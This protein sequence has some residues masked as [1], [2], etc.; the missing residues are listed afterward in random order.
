MKR[1]YNME[2]D[3]KEQIKIAKMVLKAYTTGNFE[4]LFPF[5]IDDYEHSSFWVFDTLTGKDACIKYYKRIGKAI[6]KGSM[7]KG[8]IVKL[9]SS[10]D[11]I[12]VILEQEIDNKITR[13]LI[14]PTLTENELLKS[15]LVTEPGLFH[16][17]TLE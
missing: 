6:Q 15:I 11:G 7:P 5:M 17:E 2:I 8:F 1:F 14:I 16:F 4:E 9:K 13:V 12:A 3:E 10:L